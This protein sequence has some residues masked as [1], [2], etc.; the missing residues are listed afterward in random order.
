MKAFL[1]ILAASLL[2]ALR[3]APAVET[4]QID[5]VHS[6]A[7]FKIKHLVSRVTGRFTEFSGVIAGDP[8][9]PEEAQVSVE[10]NTASINTNDPKRDEHLRSAE[11]FDVAQFPHISFVS[12]KVNQTGEDS[13]FVI[14][15]LTLRGVTKE[16]ILQTKFLGRG[17]DAK[18]LLRTGWEARTTLKRSDFGLTWSKAIEGTQ[19]V[20]NDVEIELNIEAVETRDPEKP[21]T[22]E[23]TSAPAAAPTATLPAVFQAPDAKP[24]EAPSTSDAPVAVPSSKEAAVPPGAP[25]AKEAATAPAPESNAQEKANPTSPAKDGATTIEAGTQGE[26]SAKSGAGVPQK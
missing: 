20:G 11:F 1:P 14:G 16:V 13:A 9:Q 7:S 4:Y 21:A 18:G 26:Q 3:S 10:I 8:A 6:S 24:A 25:A 23:T 22:T 5:P 2:L 15:D 19:V 17:K 12:K